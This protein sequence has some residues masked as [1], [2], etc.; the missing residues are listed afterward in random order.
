M[1]LT[2]E[3]GF[4]VGTEVELTAPS[5]HYVLNKKNPVKGGM[6][7]CI[8][9]IS[10]VIDASNV[11]V[12]WRKHGTSNCYRIFELSYAEDVQEYRSIW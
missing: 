4:G 6:Y 12:R 3:R 8:G 5:P 2:S 10:S 11:N 9:V 1:V 7:S